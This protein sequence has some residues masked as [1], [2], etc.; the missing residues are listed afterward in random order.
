[1]HDNDSFRL[2]DPDEA[3]GIGCILL[4]I[5]AVSFGVEEPKAKPQVAERCPVTV[6][7]YG[8]AE[9]WIAQPR[10]PVCAGS[11]VELNNYTFTS[12]LEI[13]R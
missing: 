5:A 4:A 12:P 7:Q 1:M 10:Q 8:A 3:V 9:R 2:I 6:A 13:R 11:P